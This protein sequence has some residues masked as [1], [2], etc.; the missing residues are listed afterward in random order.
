MYS[1]FCLHDSL[2]SVYSVSF[3][4]CALHWP[5]SVTAPAARLAAD[6][7]AELKMDGLQLVGNVLSQKMLQSYCN[8][9]GD[10]R[11]GATKVSS[12]FKE[13]THCYFYKCSRMGPAFL[14]SGL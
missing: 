1:V 13:S 2:C 5:R 11:L 10:I 12:D 7:V 14:K 6:H 8:S 9:S 3:S 4:S